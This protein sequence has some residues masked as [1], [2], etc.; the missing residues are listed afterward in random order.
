VLDK[1]A[2]K[3]IDIYKVSS[4]IIVLGVDDQIL[5]GNFVSF[6]KLLPWNHFG[7]KNLG[8]LYAIVNEAEIVYD[9]DDDN[10]LNKDSSIHFNDVLTAQSIST[11][12]SAVNP[13]YVFGC[14]KN[15]CWPRGFPYTDLLN[16]EAN[17]KTTMTVE[18]IPLSSVAVIQ[19]LA[20]HDPDVDAFMRLSIGVP[21]DFSAKSIFFSVPRKKY[22]PLNA[23]ATFFLKPA[24]F[25]LYLPV[26]VHGR[27]SDIWRSY[28][29]EFFFNK[30]EYRTLFASP[31]VTQIRNS[32][33]YLADLSSENQ[34]Y[35]RA[36]TLI[37]ILQKISYAG[38]YSVDELVI[39]V[40]DDLYERDFFGEKD[41]ILIREWIACLREL[42]FLFKK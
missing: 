22:A 9:F 23:Q 36:H 34:L 38:S 31:L 18:S 1:K 21:F 42:S 39:R 15:P 28:I 19:S 14:P 16:S 35:M 27:V 6:A 30:M 40:Y 24:F 5:I 11:N 26:T 41:L 7:R 10:I 13:Y 4:N 2:P 17:P 25:S 29:A 12:A 8:Y 32:H 37:D 33:N 3:N 20:N